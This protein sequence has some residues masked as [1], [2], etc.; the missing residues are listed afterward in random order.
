M[1][2]GYAY[3][4]GE[5]AAGAVTAI[6]TAVPIHA[7]V[8]RD[9]D[10]VVAMLAGMVLGTTAHLLVLALL[11]PLVG[12]F[13]VMASGALIGMYGGMLFGMRDSMQS[14]SWSWAVAVAV[15]VGI[16]VVAAVQL[17]DRAL[18]PQAERSPRP[19]ANS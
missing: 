15:A 4:F 12:F 17:Y 7:L 13:Q 14:V 18:R 5:Y 3:L 9:W 11:G 19:E 2:R 8:D 6:A 1:N 10:M 16:L